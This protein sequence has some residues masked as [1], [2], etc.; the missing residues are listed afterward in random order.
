MSLTESM[1]NLFAESMFG[2]FLEKNQR[3]NDK[4][5]KEYEDVLKAREKYREAVT[6]MRYGDFSDLGIMVNVI[7]NYI[8]NKGNEID[9][10]EVKIIKE[11]FEKLDIPNEKLHPYEIPIMF[12][13]KILCKKIDKILN[14]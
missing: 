9:K 7:N 13:F 4:E 2:L 5:M 14:N 12:D 6:E 3:K 1:A 8:T 10:D 11:L